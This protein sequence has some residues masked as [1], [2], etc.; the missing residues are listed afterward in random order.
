MANNHVLT[1]KRWGYL[2]VKECENIY[3]TDLLRIQIKC[4]IQYDRLIIT[5]TIFARMVRIHNLHLERFDKLEIKSA[6][7]MLVLW[8]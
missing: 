7:V 5:L 1:V 3:D 4:R 8:S 2:R 6:Q